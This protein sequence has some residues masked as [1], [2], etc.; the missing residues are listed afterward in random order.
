MILFLP[1]QKGRGPN[2]PSAAGLVKIGELMT[3]VVT[4]EGPEEAGILV[5]ECTA[6][7]GGNS[8]IMLTDKVNKPN[9][10]G[11]QT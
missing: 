11:K 10:R 2:A 8:T 6:S 4:V 3:L 1:P 9:W 5:R 7:D